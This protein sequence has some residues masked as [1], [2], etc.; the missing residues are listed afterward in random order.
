LVLELAKR[1]DIQSKIRQEITQIAAE[2]NSQEWANYRPVYEDLNKMKYIDNTMKE[3]QRLWPIAPNLV[4]MSREADQ[5]ENI[6]IPK[7]VIKYSWKF[8][9]NK[10]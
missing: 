9:I 10:G 6:H 4:R 1:P 7:G 3:A 2:N 5:Y 8:L